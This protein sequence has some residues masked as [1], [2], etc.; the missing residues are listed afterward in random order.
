MCDNEV[1]D[2]NLFYDKSGNLRMYVSFFNGMPDYTKGKWHP[3][4]C[5]INLEDHA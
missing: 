1:V 4:C 3:H 2:L 5:I